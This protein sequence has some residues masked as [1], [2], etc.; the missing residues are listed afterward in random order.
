MTETIVDDPATFLHALGSLHDVSILR[1]AYFAK[2]NR[3]E[4]EVWDLNWDTE[5][6]R[7]H[8]PRPATLVFTGVVA[9][10]N[11]SRLRQVP[12]QPDRRGRFYF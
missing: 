10:G 5:G 9:F 8:L 1:Q 4:I 3:L 6:M 12:Y 2:E 11:R 7:G